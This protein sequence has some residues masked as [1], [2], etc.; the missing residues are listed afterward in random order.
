MAIGAYDATPMQMA[1]AYTVFAN[2]G[3]HIDP[4]MLASVRAPNGDVIADYAPQTKPVLDPRAAFLTLS[5]MEQVLNNPHGTGAGVRNM[6]FTAPAA[7]K[8]GTSHD[9][10]YAGFTSNLLCIVWVGNDDYSDVKLE[11][12]HAAG[13][14]F[15][16]F[17]KNAVKLPEYSDTRDFVP[18]AG[19]VQVRLDDTTNLLADNAC[20]QDYT[21]AFLDGTQP[22]DTCDHSMGDQRNLFQKIFGLGQRSVSPAPPP[23]QQAAHPAGPPPPQAAPQPSVA[24]TQPGDQ[25]QDD[26][27]KKKPGFWG[28][29][30]GKKDD[31]QQQNQPNQPN[32]PQ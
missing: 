8:T 14:I 18:P 13:P 22:T 30:F 16:D 25:N 7:G 24:Q 5:M 17:M 9:A 4:W 10:W 32:P 6:G 19:V 26:K 2:D 29:L 11:G 20:P 27:K 23:Q 31:S 3:V 21:A 12:A 28:R 1:G 15:A